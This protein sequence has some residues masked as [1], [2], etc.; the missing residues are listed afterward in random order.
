MGA[1]L[2]K[3]ENVRLLELALDQLMEWAKTII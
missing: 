2:I 3:P 1:L